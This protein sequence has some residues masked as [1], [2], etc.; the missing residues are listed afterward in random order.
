MHHRLATRGGHIDVLGAASAS[1]VHDNPAR[2][3]GYNLYELSDEGAIVTLSSFCYDEGK[4]S[5]DAAAL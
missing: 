5:F 4:G 2:M 3:A 1:L